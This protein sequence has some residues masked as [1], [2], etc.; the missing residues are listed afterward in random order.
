M[1]FR[2]DVYPLLRRAIY[3]GCLGAALL[4]PFAALG[5]EKLVENGVAQLHGFLAKIDTL[6]GQFT[7]RM[8]LTTGEVRVSSGHF[9]LKKPDKFRWQYEKP[10]E[11]LLISN[12]DRFWSYDPELEQVTVQPSSDKWLGATPAAL[13]TGQNIEQHFT[14][15]NAGVSDGLDWLEAKPLGESHFSLLRVALRNFLPYTMEI[16]DHFGQI[17]RLELTKLQSNQ[18][19]PEETFSLSPPEGVEILVVE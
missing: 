15:S 12:G 3:Y 11:Q 14:L 18:H 17:T 13:L 19:V 2:S 4:L 5:Q 8:I 7:Q 9:L 10:F 16:Y 6:Q 1:L